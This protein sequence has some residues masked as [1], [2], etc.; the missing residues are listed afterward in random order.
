M[1]PAPVLR[2][3][4]PTC[5]GGVP[6]RGLT[7]LHRS[8]RPPLPPPP[9]PAAAATALCA[10][11]LSHAAVRPACAVRGAGHGQPPSPVHGATLRQVRVSPQTELKA[12]TAYLCD[13]S[14]L[15]LPV[16]PHRPP[17][18]RNLCGSA[19]RSGAACPCSRAACVLLQCAF[20]MHARTDQT[21][22]LQAAGIVERFF[23]RAPRAPGRADER[24]GAALSGHGPM[25]GV[26]SLVW[27]VVLLAAPLAAVGLLGSASPTPSSHCWHILM[28][29]PCP[30]PPAQGSAHVRC[31]RLC[32]CRPDAG[33]LLCGTDRGAIIITRGVTATAFARPSFSSL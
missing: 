32:R 13:A 2:R 8:R 5:G 20:E 14:P 4:V 16:S 22:V 12:P 21:A 19:S 10:P 31:R 33:T 28:M 15:L 18:D 25:P 17:Y 6:R 27:C 30:A 1:C 23:A 3:Q 24:A 7:V 26:V 11:A 29:P 9:L